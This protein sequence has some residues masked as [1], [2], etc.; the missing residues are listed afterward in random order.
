MKFRRRPKCGFCSIY[1]RQILFSLITSLI[2]KS[3]ILQIV[4]S[5]SVPCP[6]DQ[7]FANQRGYGNNNP[8]YTYFQV[9]SP[10]VSFRTYNNRGTPQPQATLPP[11]PEE[12]EVEEIDVNK[13]E[14]QNKGG[15]LRNNYYQQQQ[16]SG[17]LTETENEKV[18]NDLLNKNNNS[19][20]N[21]FNISDGSVGPGERIISATPAPIGS[22]PASQTVQT[23][24]IVVNHPFETVR[25]VEEEEQQAKVQ[26]VTVNQRQ[27]R[28]FK[29][30][31]PSSRLVYRQPVY[32]QQYYNGYPAGNYY[33]SI[34]K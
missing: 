26:E 21:T 10:G 28:L 2:L 13:E 24:R 1:L 29:S 34:R 4:Y 32:Q 3:L 25:V 16:R 8:V 7:G 19:N 14:F 11:P 9:Q 12:G 20:S 17:R 31:T 15:R 30:A 27:T 33:R 6:Q 23:R 22:K 18:Y 5:P